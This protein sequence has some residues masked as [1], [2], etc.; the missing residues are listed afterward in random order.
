MTVVTAT[1]LSGGAKLDKPYEVIK[2]E[3]SKQVGRIPHASLELRDGD[4]AQG[5]F[6]LSDAAFF[7]PG[8]KLEIKLR[9][10]G[11]SDTTVFKGVVVR[12][13]VQASEAGSTLRVELKD[14]AVKLTQVR[15]STVFRDQTDGDVIQKLLQD[16]GLQVGTVDSTQPKHAEL[17]QYHATD[18]DFILAR[19]DVQGLLVCAND[20][21]VSAKKMEI[22]GR[23]SQTFRYGMDEVYA[24]DLEIDGLS[25]YSKIKSVGWDIGDQAPTS[26]E[27]AQ[28]TS[29]SQGNLDGGRIADDL[30]LPTA[31]LSQLTPLP[32]AELKRW[33]NARLARSRL[34]L[35]RGTITVRGQADIKPLDLV[36]LQRMGQRFNGTALVTGVEHEVG[37]QNWK[38]TL[39]LGLDPAWFSHEE[40]VTAVP[41]AGLLPAVTGLQVGIVD[42]FE[43]D[44]KEELRVKVIVPAVHESEGAVWA[45]LATPDA[46]NERGYYFRP[47]KDDEVVVG[48]F[49]D[50]PRQA[51]ILG[52]LF[53]SKNAQPEYVGDPDKDNL[54]KAIVTKKG[55]IIGFKDDDN[56]SVFIETPDENKILLSDDD[57]CIKL[58][59]QHGNSITLDKDGITIK[60][61]KD[62]EIS[63][64]G[65]LKIKASSD[66][67]IASDSKVE[68]E[69]P[70]TDVM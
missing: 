44:P 49:N 45:R 62:L 47:E 17:V 58:T 38:T 60:S 3:T 29:L 7:E 36:D 61:V 63:V 23:G 70:K 14:E 52:A 68:I 40:D 56:P 43:E 59:D 53:S 5:K 11:K 16:G 48:F 22:R 31:T 55:T 42:E 19:A 50:D 24:L 28:E 6:A 67:K 41:A 64:D 69:A 66:I 30:G 65:K 34:A 10:E 54:K 35:I 15:K 1:I 32:S 9:Y 27:Q 51:V 8:K 21:A 12:H 13:G 39:T 33:A 4:V 20:G 37:A 57:E 25:Q 26:A 18:W 46:G 2:V